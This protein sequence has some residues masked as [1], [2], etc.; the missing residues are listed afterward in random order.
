MKFEIK[1]RISGAVIFSLECESMMLCV[2]AAVKSG[3]SLDGAILIDASLDGAILID[4][5][6]EGAILEGASL[7]GASQVNDLG[8]PNGWNAFAWVKDN[9]VMVQVG[10][11]SF[12]LADGRAYWTGKEN[13]REVMAAL[14][15]AEKIAEI[16]G[17][18]TK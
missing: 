18:I 17:W 5:S 15:Y 8:Q 3:A 10:C 1:H 16:R 11:R 6:L 4:A 14:D 12:T 13:R 2:E 7:D 9:Q